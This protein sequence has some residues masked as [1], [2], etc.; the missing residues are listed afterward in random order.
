MKLK[1]RGSHFQRDSFLDLTLLSLLAIGIRLFVW[2][3]ADDTFITSK[4][5]ICRTRE[6]F[7]MINQDLFLPKSIWL[8]LYQ[9]LANLNLKIFGITT[10]NVSVI[11]LIFGTLGVFPIYLISRLF[12]PRSLSILNGIIFCF[13]WPHVYLSSLAMTEPLFITLVAMALYFYLK[14]SLLPSAFAIILASITRYEGWFFIVTLPFLDFS[15]S[16][17]RAWVKKNFIFWAC[18]SLGIL[19]VLLYNFYYVQEHPLVGFIINSL[20]AKSEKE[21]IPSNTMGI[22]VYFLNSYGRPFSFILIFGL[23]L[24]LWKNKNKVVRNVSAILTLLLAIKLY[25]IFQQDLPAEPRY[26]LTGV[27]LALPFVFYQISKKVSLQKVI[28]LQVILLLPLVILNIRQIEA[29]KKRSFPEGLLEMIEHLE[30]QYHLG[31]V[32]IS[33]LKDYNACYLETKVPLSAGMIYQMPTEHGKYLENYHQANLQFLKERIKKEN[34]GLI[35]LEKD[36]SPYYPLLNDLDPHH[37]PLNVLFEN[38]QYILIDA[39][40]PSQK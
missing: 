27:S 13:L 39:I 40:K 32:V 24:N 7:A 3:I 1:W 6:V 28:L 9:V 12:F 19:L 26:I 30:S 23:A 36:F 38:N 4:D 31:T 16:Q 10:A 20:L 18:S 8:P 21:M 25:S 35:I 17:W 33:D 2:R 15:L 29:V 34:W 11:G 5:A 37:F 14:S 22:I